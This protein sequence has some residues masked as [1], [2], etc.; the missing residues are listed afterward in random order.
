M[1]L[2]LPC[3]II[4]VQKAALE[5]RAPTACTDRSSGGMASKQYTQYDSIFGHDSA[6]YGSRFCYENKDLKITS[7]D[8]NLMSKCISQWLCMPSPACPSVV[9]M[10]GAN[11][12]IPQD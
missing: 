9:V 2:F 12:P 7:V 4:L 10:H 3:G 1:L 8:V 5:P 11:L 6:V